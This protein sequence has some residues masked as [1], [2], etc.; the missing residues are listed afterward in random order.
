V[1]K[2]VGAK[3]PSPRETVEYRKKSQGMTERKKVGRGQRWPDVKGKTK[4]WRRKAVAVR[5]EEPITILPR[6]RYRPKQSLQRRNHWR[7]RN[8]GEKFGKRLDQDG[9][10]K[11]VMPLNT[12]GWEGRDMEQGETNTQLFPDQRGEG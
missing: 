7:A 11:R 6:D 5:P 8:M 2:R 3:I 9:E 1:K 10:R 4:C 12:S